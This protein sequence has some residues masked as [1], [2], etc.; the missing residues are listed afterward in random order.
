MW[1]SNA[2]WAPTGYGQQTALF[3]PRLQALGHEIAISAFFGLQGGMGRWGDMPV[4]PQDITGLGKKMLPHY[5]RHFSDTGSLDD[6]QVI[7]LMD[8]WTWIDPTRGGIADFKGLNLAAW[9]PVDHDPIPPAVAD[10]LDRFATRKIAMSRFGE[11]QMREVGFD[12]WYI[13]HGV[14]TEVMQPRES[15]NQI[16]ESMRIP[17]DAFVVGMVANNQGSSP[18][19]KAF[20]QVF[21]AFAEFH[22]RHPDTFL[23]LHCEQSGMFD[24]INLPAAALQCGIPSEA[25][26]FIDQTKYLMGDISQKEMSHIYSFMDVLANPSYGEGFGIP[27]VEAQACGV[28]VIVTDWTAMSE[29]CGVGWKVQG[30]AWYDC[31]HGVDFMCPSIYEIVDAFEAAYDQRDVDVRADAREFAMQYDADVVVETYWKPAL[32]LLEQELGGGSLPAATLN[33]KQRRAKDRGKTV[34]A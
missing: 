30:D 12:P 4:Y 28:P 31:G 21:R 32:E 19:R 11:E 20:P 27:I 29:L 9:A 24:G 3:L 2:P 17:E 6:V 34:A 10:A 25:V 7:S 1:H 14:D 22:R 13:P 16:R 18:P 23:Y 15:R 26:A 5:V 33:R 8:A